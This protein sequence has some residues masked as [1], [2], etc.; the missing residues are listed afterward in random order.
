MKIRKK[1]VAMVC[2]C[3]LTVAGSGMLCY[4]TSAGITATVTK[5]TVAGTYNYGKYGGTVGIK[6]HW[7][8]EHKTTHQTYSDWSERSVSGNAT[9][10]SVSRNADEGYEYTRADFYGYYNGSQLASLEG[11]T[12]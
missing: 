5:G 10:A 7:R 1:L 6:V 9:S 8:E 11:V 12:P 2:V 3:V 4:A